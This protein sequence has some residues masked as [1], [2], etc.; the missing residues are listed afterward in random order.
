MVIIPASQVSKGAA[1]TMFSAAKIKYK[2]RKNDIYVTCVDG[3]SFEVT[4][5]AKYVAFV[6]TVMESDDPETELRPGLDLL[7]KTLHRFVTVDDVYAPVNDSSKDMCHIS[8]SLDAST[9]FQTVSEDVLRLYRDI[10]GEELDMSIDTSG[11]R[12]V[13]A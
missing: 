3:S 9:H 11:V 10:M 2:A 7:G 6:S 13:E 8:H 4:A 1:A 12:K 5:P